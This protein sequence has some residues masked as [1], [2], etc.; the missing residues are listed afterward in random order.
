MGKKIETFQ[1]QTVKYFHK[2]NYLWGKNRGETVGK[3]F[4]Q[5]YILANKD[6]G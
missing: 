3:E 6:R 2:Q 5:Y 4:S 1:H